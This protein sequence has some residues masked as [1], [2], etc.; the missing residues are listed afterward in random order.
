MLLLDALALTGGLV[1]LVPG[2]SV[3]PFYSWLPS[4]FVTE[5]FSKSPLKHILFSIGK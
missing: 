1:Y 4:W 2:A 5:T 3:F